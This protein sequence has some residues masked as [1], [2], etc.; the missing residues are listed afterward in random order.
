MQYNCTVE[1]VSASNVLTWWHYSQ[2]N[3]YTKIF[4]SH[5]TTRSSS[6]TPILSVT[7]AN[8]KY[9][10]KGFYNLFVHNVDMQS[11][12]GDYICEISGHKN[13]SASLTVVGEYSIFMIFVAGT[14]VTH[15]E[16]MAW[17]RAP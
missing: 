14:L 3:G 17:I 1:G 8:S 4:Q 11:D 2:T 5:T 9:E 6:H 10:I 16:V 15:R 13:Y 12:S 7:N